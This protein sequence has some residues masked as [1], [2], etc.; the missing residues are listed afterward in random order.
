MSTS[1]E[2]SAKDFLTV[3]NYIFWQE[4]K[5][6]WGGVKQPEAEESFSRI[7]GIPVDTITR[8]VK[9]DFDS[10]MIKPEDEARND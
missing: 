6:M 9:P 3:A 10:M 8:I 4:K 5:S 2:I 7:V 1:K